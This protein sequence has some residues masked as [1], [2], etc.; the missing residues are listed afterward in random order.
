[1]I[2][3][4][5]IH[6]QKVSGIEFFI[7]AVIAS[8][9]HGFHHSS[10]ADAARSVSLSTFQNYTIESDWVT[11]L[12]SAQDI[13]SRWWFQT[14]NT[15]YFHPYLGWWSKLTNIFQ[16]GWNR[17]LVINCDW[18]IRKASE[19]RRRHLVSWVALA[20]RSW[21]GWSLRAQI[22]SR[23]HDNKTFTLEKAAIYPIG[24]MGLVY[25]YLHLVDFLW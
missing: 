2:S 23:P 4:I 15:F 5:L 17:Q 3:S 7:L 6:F 13:L 16:M 1:M 12:C 24:S 14:S 21:V 11:E 20:R 9:S 8:C 22:W 25:F 10:N 19:N 18:K